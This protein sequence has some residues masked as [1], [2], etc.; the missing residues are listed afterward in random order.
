M[1]CDGV[2]LIGG[3]ID[4]T[5]LMVHLV[6]E[7]KKVHVLHVDYGQKAIGGEYDAIYYFTE[8]YKVPFHKTLCRLDDIAQAAILKNS[9]M[10]LKHV[11]NR[12]EGRNVILVGLAATLA[13]S[14]GS[15]CVWTGFHKEP[16]DRPFPD[17]TIEARDAMRLVL[18]TA[19]G[20]PMRLQA[21]FWNKTR[22]E[23]FKYAR[24]LDPEIET[25]SYT[26]YEVPL[27][28][29]ECGKCT[30]CQQKAEMQKELAKCVV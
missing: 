17:A 6:R 15:A 7:G 16:E 12:L 10:G 14:L 22:L 30:H 9:P 18:A 3:G 29:R 21:P 5:T 25:R 24:E 20:T 19:Y 26:C 8:K 2:L 27:V 28:G 23:I 13:H 11:D 1:E 4:S